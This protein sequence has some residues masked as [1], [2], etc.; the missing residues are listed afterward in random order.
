MITSFLQAD[1]YNP[2]S[3]ESI[4]FVIR[5]ENVARM[6]ATKYIGSNESLAGEREGLYQLLHSGPFRPGQLLGKQ[7]YLCA[8]S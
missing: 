1:G 2:L 5:N 8:S 6:L 7:N 3:I 4:V